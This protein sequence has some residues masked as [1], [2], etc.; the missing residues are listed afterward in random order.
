MFTHARQLAVKKWM[1]ENMFY[2]NMDKSAFVTDK[3][4]PIDFN[5]RYFLQFFLYIHCISPV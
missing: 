2:E 3:T 4:L 5:E 1:F